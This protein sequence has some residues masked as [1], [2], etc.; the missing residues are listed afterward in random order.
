MHDEPADA[1]VAGGGEDA[2]R[3]RARRYRQSVAERGRRHHRSRPR[4]RRPGQPAVADRPVAGSDLRRELG[5]RPGQS[6]RHL[7]TPHR[8]RP[9]GQRR[10]CPRPRPGGNGGAAHNRS[11]LVTS[12]T[13]EPPAHSWT[14]NPHSLQAPTTLASSTRRRAVR[15]GRNNAPHMPRRLRQSAAST[16]MGVSAASCGDGCRRP[17]AAGSDGGEGERL[18]GLLGDRVV[19]GRVGPAG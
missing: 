12:R 18:V 2:R 16:P 6:R 15:A 9:G 1:R 5:G 17:G 10:R 11:R 19:G 4:S 14:Q 13:A 8:H 3:R 7:D